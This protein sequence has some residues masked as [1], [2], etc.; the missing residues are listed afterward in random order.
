MQSP[1]KWRAEHRRQQQQQQSKVA[2]NTQTNTQKQHNQ[3]EAWS[4]W[5]KSETIEYT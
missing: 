5:I 1:I 2:M 3:M 4:K